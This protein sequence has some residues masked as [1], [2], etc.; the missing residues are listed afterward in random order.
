MKHARTRANK[1]TRSL[2]ARKEQGVLSH[3]GHRERSSPVEY[4]GNETE[5]RTHARETCRVAFPVD[6]GGVAMPLKRA[7][8]NNGKRVEGE[9]RATR[10]LLICARVALVEYRS[11]ASSYF[12]DLYLSLQEYASKGNSAVQKRG[13]SLGGRHCRMTAPASPWSQPANDVRAQS[14][15]LDI[16]LLRKRQRRV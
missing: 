1:E 9:N 11:C 12:V 14:F 5:E 16:R 10:I 3:A 13:C 6:R 2:T 8:E 7:N 4:L 15:I